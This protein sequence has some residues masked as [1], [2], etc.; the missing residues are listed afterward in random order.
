MATT[1]RHI[2]FW[3][4]PQS[5]PEKN[6]NWEEGIGVYK[7]ATIAT[8]IGYDVQVFQA[9]H[10]QNDPEII[11][12][13]L[14]TSPPDT[15]FGFSVYSQGTST[16]E[17]IL[18]NPNTPSRPVIIGGPGATVDPEDI[19]RRIPPRYPLAVV[20]GEGETI[21]EKL[22]QT[23]I[24]V[25]NS[26]PIWTRTNDGNIKHGVFQTLP[27]LGKSPF[28]N[29]DGSQMRN[30]V[31]SMV[32]DSRTPLET[33]LTALKS[34]FH[35]YIETRRGC[36]Y[37]CEFC[38][39]PL[40][41]TKGVRRM[42]PERVLEELD[43]LYE[44]HGIVFFNFVDNI[45]FDDPSWWENFTQELR[46]RPYSQWVRFGG[47]GTPKFFSHQSWKEL[48]PQ[49][50][51]VGL[52]FFTIGVQSGSPR[53]LRNVIHRPQ[54]DPQ[55]AL[56]ITEYAIKLGIQV[57]ADFIVG[58]PTETLDDLQQTLT[59]VE[60][61]YEAG[62]QIF[63]RRLTIVPKSGYDFK[64]QENEYE[65][66]EWTINHTYLVEKINSYYGRKDKFASLM[67]QRTTH[68]NIYL[69][70]RRNLVQWPR[71]NMPDS[72]VKEHMDALQHTDMHELL[73]YRYHKLYEL[74]LQEKSSVNQHDRT[75]LPQIQI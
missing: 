48:L 46:M 18:C 17:K 68:P 49:L 51:R 53:I 33:R 72:V 4:I 67:S 29:L 69:I 22:L 44:N 47:Y 62:A 30:E 71:T 74:V 41:S 64:L 25:W 34:L 6:P 8:T 11:A 35:S 66:P 24:L 9:S 65:L 5:N 39:E 73:K 55:D 1:S 36:F 28:I 10:Y 57:K 40:L 45:A 14:A 63:V 27:D 42:S 31:V 15:F 2:S 56:D 20:Q 60:K 52:C 75:N 70:D 23:P 26:L 16:L 7:L 12:D 13:K 3:T 59:C 50:Y 54:T 58:H 21:F 32:D 38:S 43:Y 61:L 37:K 19:L